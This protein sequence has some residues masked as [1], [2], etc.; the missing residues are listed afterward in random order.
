M[1]YM[2]LLAAC[3]AGMTGTAYAANECDNPQDQGTL[4]EC[5]DKAFRKSDADLNK[6]YKQIEARAKGDAD[7]AKLL[8]TAQRAWIAFRDAECDF[9]SSSSAGGS[10]YPML[11]LQCRDGMTQ[12]RI[13]EFRAYLTCRDD[14]LQ[15]PLPADEN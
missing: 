7:K 10:I 8:V 14:D 4:T 1:K 9:A 11:V 2:L 6:L 15:C 13:K 12:A 5:A 3:L